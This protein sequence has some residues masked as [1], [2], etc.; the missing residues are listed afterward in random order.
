L[1]S[2]L[3]LTGSTLIVPL[4]VAANAGW[5]ITQGFGVQLHSMRFN[6]HVRF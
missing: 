1:P 6:E 5:W 2:V 4:C 3:R